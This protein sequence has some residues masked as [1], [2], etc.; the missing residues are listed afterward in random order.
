MLKIFLHFLLADFRALLKALKLAQ[1]TN[2][3]V[4]LID[5]WSRS[6]RLVSQAGQLQVGEVGEVG[7]VQF[8]LSF[9]CF[10]GK[11]SSYVD[12]DSF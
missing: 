2:R 12:L 5:F 6:V 4:Y 8:F 10:L 7:Q 9:F 1:P 3:L 11:G